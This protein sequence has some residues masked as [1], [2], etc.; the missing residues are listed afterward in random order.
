MVGFVLLYPNKKILWFV[1]C[2]TY[3]LSDFMAAIL[4]FIFYKKTHK[5]ESF[6]SDQISP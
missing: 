3:N 6:T 1:A 5:D 4:N 2:L